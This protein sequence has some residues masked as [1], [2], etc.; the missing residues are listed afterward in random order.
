MDNKIIEN[1]ISATLLDT[2]KVQNILNA[3]FV[4]NNKQ[5]IFRVHLELV[6]LG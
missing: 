2:E 1:I 3:M 5:L 6:R 4:E